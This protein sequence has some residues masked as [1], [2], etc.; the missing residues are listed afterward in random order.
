M[1]RMSRYS[2]IEKHMTREKFKAYHLGLSGDCFKLSLQ[3]A[4]SNPGSFLCWV[5]LDMSFSNTTFDF[6]GFSMFSSETSDA[7]VRPL[8][9]WCRSPVRAVPPGEC[10]WLGQIDFGLDLRWG[11]NEGY[12][13]WVMN[14]CV[15]RW[16][17]I[18]K[19]YQ[20]PQISAI[21]NY[22][23]ICSQRWRWI[24]AICFYSLFPGLWIDLFLQRCE[25]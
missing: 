20:H 2:L 21:V 7:K 15:F 23:L 18:S 14:C 10:Q 19:I 8:R 3:L 1:S 13:V 22:D 9:S 25:D 17:S 11:P 24:F 16:V 12:E 6:V 4:Y 5:M